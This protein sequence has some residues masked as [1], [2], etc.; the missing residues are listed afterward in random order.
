MIAA[1]PCAVTNPD[2]THTTQSLTARENARSSILYPP[3]G[4]VPAR[5]GHTRLDL[6]VT[7]V[8]DVARNILL[9]AD[10]C[11]IAKKQYTVNRL[12]TDIGVCSMGGGGEVGTGARGGAAT[13]G[14]RHERGREEAMTGG[15]M[16]GVHG[17][18]RGS[19]DARRRSMRNRSRSRTGARPGTGTRV[20]DGQAK[21]WSTAYGTWE[22][23]SGG[24][25][26]TGDAQGGTELAREKEEVWTARR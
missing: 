15:W 26:R 8:L 17:L 1:P 19:D 24:E 21:G 14:K 16:A 5:H 13:A 6:R 4:S 25:G 2:F 11:D 20:E 10:M 12:S 22:P 23:T 9:P 7:T 3:S 18:A